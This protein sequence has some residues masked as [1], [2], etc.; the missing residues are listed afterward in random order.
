MALLEGKRLA[1]EIKQ[2]H[3]N[4]AARLLAHGI[5]PQLAIIQVKDDPVINTY[6]KLKQI[7]GQDIGV[8]VVVHK[9]SQ[10]KTPDLINKLNNTAGVHGIIVQLPLPDPA[11]T[12]EVVNLV[13]PSKDVDALGR[14]AQFQPATPMAILWL[15]EGNHIKLDDKKVLLI[16]RGKLVGGPLEKILKSR[17]IEVTV[18]DQ[19][20]PDL[21]RLTKKADIII[22]A[23]SSPGVVHADMLHSGAVVVDAGV[24][25]EEGRVVGDVDPD[26]YK[27]DD[28]TI[29]PQKGGVGPLTVCALFENLL[30]AANAI[31]N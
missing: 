24:A 29:T 31:K 11:G 8:Q 23:T 9:P 21:S 12:D 4:E 22:T 15:L 26:V 18:I 14:R 16:G 10:T 13:E 27:R 17:G 25:A 28:V 19:P 20:T 3:T 30:Q 7:Y 1:A 5:M 2:R 6:V